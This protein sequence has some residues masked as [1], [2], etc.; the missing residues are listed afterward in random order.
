MGSIATQLSSSKCVSAPSNDSG[1]Q[2]S[3]CNRTSSLI[4]TVSRMKSVGL[5]REAVMCL[6]A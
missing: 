1:S 2:V 3:L 5:H 6:Q 4:V